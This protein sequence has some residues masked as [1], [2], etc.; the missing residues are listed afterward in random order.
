M[1]IPFIFWVLIISIEVIVYIYIQRKQ[2]KENQNRIFSILSI[3]KLMFV[4]ILV[5]NLKIKFTI[6][7]FGNNFIINEFILVVDKFILTLS[8]I[9][10]LT[11][12]PFII[13]NRMYSFEFFIFLVLTNFGLLI[14]LG[15]MDFVSFFISFELQ[16]FC[17]YALSLIKKNSLISNES[18]LKYFLTGALISSIFILGCTFFYGFY[19]TINIIDLKIITENKSH[20]FN[21]F[22]IF[23]L[24]LFL[25]K[26]GFFPFG[27]WM[28]DVYEAS[29][30]SI[31]FFFSSIPKIVYI[32]LLIV[33]FNFWFKF[34]V[35]NIS[36]YLISFS[37]LSII[38]GS[39]FSLNQV[40]F[41]RLITYSGISQMGY[42]VLALSLQEFD[43]I[44]ASV[45]SLFV[46][47][48]SNYLIWGLLFAANIKHQA[49]LL[50][51][52][53]TFSRTKKIL[54][55]G[56]FII[57]FSFAGLP[58]FLGFF[59]KLMILNQMLQDYQFINVI[60]I[61]IISSTTIFYYLK[62]IYIVY[63]RNINNYFYNRIFSVLEIKKTYANYFLI[64][65]AMFIIT[66]GILNSNFILN[67]SLNMLLILIN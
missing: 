60:V 62:I 21:S 45:F 37:V 22:S 38:W 40:K 24:L 7:L 52:F 31:T 9:Y 35:L 65:V 54:S 63:F 3:Q 48:L 51:D 8:L 14:L 36:W 23:F 43:S 59:S 56:I 18:A 34:N 44:L 17:L 41:K 28:P 30:N 55:L 11:I 1:L 27:Q 6:F 64:G 16:T 5:F 47:I 58:P 25:Y 26:L 57:L 39:L 32:F 4:L 13:E 50:T 20:F 29:Q 42:I 66:F 2:K 61:C 33:I 46:Y 19:G 67:Y 10:L 15:C 12:Q 53:I 49:L